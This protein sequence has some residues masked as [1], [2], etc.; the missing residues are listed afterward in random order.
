MTRETAG[1]K[2]QSGCLPNAKSTARFFGPEAIQSFSETERNDR[3]STKNTLTDRIRASLS[4][5][6]NFELSHSSDKA[7]RSASFR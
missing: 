7:R 3:F 6:N 4:A 1:T 5:K 2:F